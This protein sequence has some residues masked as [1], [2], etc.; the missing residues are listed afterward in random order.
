MSLNAPAYAVLTYLVVDVVSFLQK[1]RAVLD[2]CS[3]A[4]Q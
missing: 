3:Q 2:G 4:A 1:M